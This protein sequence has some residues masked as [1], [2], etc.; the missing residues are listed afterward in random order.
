MTLDIR[1]VSESRFTSL[2]VYADP[3]VGKTRF[4][5][6]SPGKVLIIRPPTDH[7]DSLLPKDKKRVSEVVVSDWSTMTDLVEYLRME[8]DK[9]D[10]VWVDSV[11]LLQDHLLDDIW[12]STVAAKPSR[13]ENGLDKRE[14]GLNMQ[15]LSTWFRDVIGPDLFNFGFTAHA[16]NTTVSQDEDADEKLMPYVQGKMMSQ[17]FAGYANIVAYMEVAKIG[18]QD[19]RRVLRL[20][21]TD[22]YYAKDQFDLTPDHRIVDPTMPKLVSL[23]E[24]KRGAVTTEK[25]PATK[26]TVARKRKAK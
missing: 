5:G 1:K 15:K 13:A 26:R 12:E 3:G 19:D 22:R 2:C 23:I 17:K 14:Y 25:K 9:W 8:G 24:A 11:S 6:T 18:G 21:S 4:L 16:W 7:A 10:W 20:G